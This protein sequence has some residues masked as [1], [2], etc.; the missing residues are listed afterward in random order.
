MYIPQ[1][2]DMLYSMVNMKLRDQ[3][4][5]FEELCDCEDLDPA[6]IMVRLNAAGY[7]Y[8]EDHNKFTPVLEET[9]VTIEEDDRT[10]ID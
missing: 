8:D 4:E 5:S 1:D 10:T 7:E 6:T 9:V 3:Y 2:N